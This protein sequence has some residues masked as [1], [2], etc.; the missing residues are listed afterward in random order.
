MTKHIDIDKTA[1]E[2]VVYFEI[3]KDESNFGCALLLSINK[4]RRD[5]TLMDS[6]SWNRIDYGQILEDN[7]NLE[8]LEKIKMSGL[9]FIL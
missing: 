6:D 1:R 7:K 8:N 4:L 5:Y 3:N 9:L 2:D